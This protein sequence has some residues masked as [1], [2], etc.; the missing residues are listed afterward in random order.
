MCRDEW[1][2]AEECRDKR[3]KAVGQ[4]GGT[5]ASGGGQE[6]DGVE[7]RGGQG[8]GEMGGMSKWAGM[9][10]QGETEGRG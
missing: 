9:L 1:V 10:G 4:M 8:A 3:D 7:E 2:G 5:Q 6:A